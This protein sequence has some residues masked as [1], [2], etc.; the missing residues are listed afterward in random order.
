MAYNHCNQDWRANA[1][2]EVRTMQPRVACSVRSL[3]TEP[4]AH[5]HYNQG[6]RAV[7]KHHDSSAGQCSR[8]WRAVPMELCKN[9]WLIVTA[10]KIGVQ[11]ADTMTEVLDHGLQ[12]LQ[13]RLACKRH[14]RS[15][16]NAAA[17]GVQC[18]ESCNR[19]HGLQSLQPRLAGS[20]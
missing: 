9:P 3:A 5:R 7:C 2:T 15:K 17:S 13:P 18:Q 10:T 20:V 16:D 8:E 19:T 14:D 6:W 1:M 11:R 4:M 12:S